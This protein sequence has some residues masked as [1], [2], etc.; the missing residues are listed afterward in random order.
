MMDEEEVSVWIV[1]AHRMG[2]KAP[3]DPKPM[4]VD[5]DGGWPVGNSGHL[6]SGSE[7]TPKTERVFVTV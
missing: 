5:P 4:L 7:K 2:A 3:V 1:L 6:A